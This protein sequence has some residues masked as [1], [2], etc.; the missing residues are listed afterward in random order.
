MIP[1]KSSINDIN[2][3][4][5]SQKILS[6]KKNNHSERSPCNNNQFQISH[7]NTPMTT[8]LTLGIAKKFPSMAFVNKEMINSNNNINVNN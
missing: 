1:A 8:K 4:S 3:Q 5:I 2:L 6:V 7:Q